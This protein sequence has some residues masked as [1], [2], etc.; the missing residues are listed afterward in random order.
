MLTNLKILRDERGISQKELSD[1]INVSQQSINKYE[2]H[3]VQPDIEILKKMADYFDTSI[4]YILG[5]TDIRK[6]IG[7]A[8]SYV[9]NEYEAG[10]IE[11]LRTLTAEER[12]CVDI[13]VRTL[14]KK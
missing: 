11:R 3:N 1:A 13:V 7:A 9:L 14:L 5:Y 10:L 6:K 8:G 2:N 4:D 12:Q